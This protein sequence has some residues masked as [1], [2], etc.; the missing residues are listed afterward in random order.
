MDVC[1]QLDGRKYNSLVGLTL[2]V[3]GTYL[4]LALQR[5]R[6][7][8]TLSQKP[9]KKKQAPGQHTIPHGHFSRNPEMDPVRVY[10]PGQYLIKAC[11]KFKAW[12]KI[13]VAVLCCFDILHCAEIPRNS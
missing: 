4:I 9:K 7:A 8:E 6:Q 12:L 2:K 3:T 10:H 1:P 13:L 5:Q 11:F